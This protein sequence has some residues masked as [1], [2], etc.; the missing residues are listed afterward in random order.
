MLE[1]GQRFVIMGDWETGQSDRIII[2]LA[3]SPS[4]VRADGMLGAARIYGYGDRSD[5][6]AFIEVIEQVVT[7][8][9]R[10]ADI[11]AGTGILAIAA[12]MLGGV[13]TAYE[14]NPDHRAMAE[15]HFELNDV[16]VDVR[17]TFPDGANGFDLALANVGRLPDGMAVELGRASQVAY[18]TDQTDLLGAERLG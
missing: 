6:A 17:E 1:V 13:V 12:S 16:D 9:M 18:V 2:R 7:P 8:G 5:T 4:R 11:G 3:P 14:M 10:V 15:Q